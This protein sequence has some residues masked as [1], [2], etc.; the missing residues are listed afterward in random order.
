MLKLARQIG[1]LFARS[2]HGFKHSLCRLCPQGSRCATISSSLVACSKT[3]ESFYSAALKKLRY[4][5]LGGGNVVLILEGEVAEADYAG[6][7]HEG[8]G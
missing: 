6:V 4:R 1:Q 5:G 3:L 8:R 7:G 2:T